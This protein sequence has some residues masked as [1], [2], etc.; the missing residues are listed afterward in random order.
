MLVTLADGTYD[1]YDD[2]AFAQGGQGTLHLSRDRRWV[3][4]L[5]HESDSTRVTAL[6]KIIGNYNVTLID[7][8]AVQLFAWP[9][10]IIKAPRLGV[11]MANVNQQMEH[12]P[13]TWWIGPRA[14]KR[15][16]PDIRGTW[17]NRIGVAIHMARIAWQLHA[18]GLCHSDFS[19]DNFLANVAYER[20]VLIDLDSLVVP[21]VLPPEMLGTGE[22][23]APEIVIGRMKGRAGTGAKPSIYTDLHSLAVLIYQLLLMR[24]PLKGP[25]RHDEDAEKDDLLALGERALYIED[26]DDISN[27]PGLTFNGAWLLGDEVDA[28][29]RRA[30]TG[31]LRNPAQRPLA[32]EWSD[33][34]I[35]M[36]EQTVPC[37]NS[38]CE[39]KAFVLLRDQP[40][41][42]PWCGTKVARPAQ[43]PV[44]RWYEGTGQAGHFHPGRGRIVVWQSRTLHRWHIQPGVSE[45]TAKEPDERQPMA[46]FQFKQNKW[47]LAN[48]AIDDLRVVTRGGVR[49]ILPDETLP[50]EDGQQLIMGGQGQGAA[51]LAL[52]A[53]Q[54][55]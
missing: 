6:N 41:I 30:F 48:H 2:D 25:R 26:P 20:V 33:A 32:A 11:R 42:C 4:K 1:N 19:G 35:R 29:M 50:L 8:S 21:G 46:E 38:E 44:L 12:K 13:L 16:S 53:M 17:L 36:R 51:R 3:A 5:Y 24:H 18:N 10:A 27:R 47:L 54:K 7:P 37:S 39:G 45:R 22:Y 14:Y 28:L 15:L 40:A 9:N 43:V 49:K 31:G 55:L 34:L 52:V 23:M